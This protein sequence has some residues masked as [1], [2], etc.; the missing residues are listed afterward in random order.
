MADAVCVGDAVADVV[1][2]A[3]GNAVADAVCMGDAVADAGGICD[4]IAN[5][6]RDAD[7]QGDRDVRLLDSPMRCIW[8]GIDTSTK[9]A[10]QRTARQANDNPATSK[11]RTAR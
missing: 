10:V 5:D 3:V 7:A 6:V 11:A 8:I 4:A 1:A 9:T 2:G